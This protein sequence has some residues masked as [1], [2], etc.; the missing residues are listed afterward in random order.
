M[1]KPL[2]KHSSHEQQQSATSGRSP[3]LQ[4]AVLSR[5]LRF[6]GKKTASRCAC[7]AVCKRWNAF[8]APY[9]GIC[10]KPRLASFAAAAAGDSATAATASAND[11]SSA[12]ARAAAA[13]ELK[14][15]KLPK[16]RARKRA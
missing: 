10:L 8:A 15:K 7:S 5:V 1:C 2:C 6:V 13:A 11:T 12:S 3:F 14:V 9:G 4:D 16:N